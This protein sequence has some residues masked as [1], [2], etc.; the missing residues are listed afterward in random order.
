MSLVAIFLLALAMST[1]AFAAAIGKGIALDRPRWSEALRTGAIFGAIEAATPSSA[2]PS[3][4]AAASYVTQWDHWIAFVILG[5]LGVH[6]IVNG[7]R[8]GD[9]EPAERPE[10]HGFWNLATTGFATSIDAMAVGVG[11]AFVDVGIVAGRR[12]DRLR[13]LRDGDDRHHARASARQPGRQARRDASAGS[14]SSPSARPSSTSISRARHERGPRRARLDRA[15]RGRQLPRPSQGLYGPLPHR[16]VGALL[17]LRNARAARA[18]H[19]EPPLRAGPTPAPRCSA[20]TRSS[21]RSSR[22]SAR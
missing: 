20:S 5:G 22:C 2:G 16:D 8:A 1:D 6:M 14:C 10:R 7:L 9:D 17:L 13:D 3:A 4:R 12:G 21:A 19:D 11:L 15:G 18:L